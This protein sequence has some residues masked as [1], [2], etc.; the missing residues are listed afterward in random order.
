MY[1][2]DK[3]IRDKNIATLLEEL[4][5]DKFIFQKRNSKHDDMNRKK[6]MRN[7]ILNSNLLE[8]NFISHA[9][10]NNSEETEVI[11]E[12]IGENKKEEEENSKDDG[13]DHG[14][15]VE[16]EEK[17]KKKKKTISFSTFA[18]QRKRLKKIKKK[19][20]EFHRKKTKYNVLHYKLMINQKNRFESAST[21]EVLKTKLEIE[22]IKEELKLESLFSQKKYTIS[23]TNAEVDSKRMKKELKKREAELIKEFEAK[24]L[25]SVD[26]RLVNNV[27]LLKKILQI[28][29]CLPKK[30]EMRKVRLPLAVRSDLISIL[31]K[32]RNAVFASRKVRIAPASFSSKT[33]EE[34]KNG[35]KSFNVHSGGLRKIKKKK[36]KIM[37]SEIVEECKKAINEQMYTKEEKV[38]KLKYFKNETD[39]VE[40]KVLVIFEFILLYNLSKYILKKRKFKF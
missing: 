26:F 20:K 19:E 16:G 31:E 29:L 40:I 13:E 6:S 2:Y 17:K 27:K 28:P 21:F 1:D 10:N 34:E 38:E 23:Y 5:V 22:K 39:F 33:S 25:Q 7:L 30:D 37:M 9:F 3:Q 18:E 8:K 35:S 11:P 15:K 32:Q 4:P 12:D 24:Y 36:K 14:Q